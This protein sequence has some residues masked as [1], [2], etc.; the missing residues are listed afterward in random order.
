MS[1][2]AGVKLYVLCNRR[3]RSVLYMRLCATYVFVPLRGHNG[4]MSNFNVGKTKAKLL[5][6][7]SP[8]DRIKGAVRTLGPLPKPDVDGDDGR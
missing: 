3:T 2:P 7:P 1:R 6:G 4:I 5:S 8:K